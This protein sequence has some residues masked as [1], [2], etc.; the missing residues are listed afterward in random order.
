MDRLGVS[1][2]ELAKEVGLDR[3]T[4]ARAREGHARPATFGLIEAWLDDLEHEAGMDLPSLQEM[5]SIVTLPDGTI[6]KF[7]GSPDGVAE[8]AEAFLLRHRH[9]NGS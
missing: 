2:R 9:V 7:Q 8:A 6:V 4:V 5:V 3:Q 1:S